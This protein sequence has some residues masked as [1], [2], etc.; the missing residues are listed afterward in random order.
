MF[1]LKFFYRHLDREMNLEVIPLIFF[2]N[3]IKEEIW[4]L[5]AFPRKKKK[6][7][8]EL[9][10]PFLTS[11]DIWIL[12]FQPNS[13]CPN[14]V[15]THFRA[16]QESS[17]STVLILILFTCSYKNKNSLPLSFPFSLSHSLSFTPPPPSPLCLSVSVSSFPLSVSL[18][19][20]PS[21]CLSL[22]LSL[23]RSEQFR[24]SVLMINLLSGYKN[25]LFLFGE[26][27]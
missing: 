14:Q 5:S 7:Q 21:L 4:N 18:F 16:D 9:V 27:S 20:S 13:L 2:D 8:S 24:Y 12:S 10:K 1:S 11:Y 15:E 19:R 6:C 22:P 25:V 17:R 3:F 23:P 26:R